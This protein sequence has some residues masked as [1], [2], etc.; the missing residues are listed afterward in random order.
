[1]VEFFPTIHKRGGGFLACA[2]IKQELKK[3]GTGKYEV[4]ETNKCKTQALN[5]IY[6]RSEKFVKEREKG[7]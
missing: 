7:K 4:I 6:D 2:F 3:E 1:M 5:F